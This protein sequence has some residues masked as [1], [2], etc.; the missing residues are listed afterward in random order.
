MSDSSSCFKSL[1]ILGMVSYFSSTRHSTGCVVVS[2]CGLIS[3]SLRN[4]DIKQ[5]FVCL[6]AI[7]VSSVKCLLMPFA[8]VYYVVTLHVLRFSIFYT[9]FMVIMPSRC[10][11]GDYLLLYS[12]LGLEKWETAIM[13]QGYFLNFILLFRFL[14]KYKICT[15][16]FHRFSLTWG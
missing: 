7:C 4:K 16:I 15:L 6:F 5:C 11:S 10:R 1:Q 12:L 14:T 8:Q 2:R 13:Q 3:I 9:F